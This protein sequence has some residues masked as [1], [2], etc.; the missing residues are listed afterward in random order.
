MSDDEEFEAEFEGEAFNSWADLD[1]TVRDRGGVLRVSMRDL[2][3]LSGYERLKVRVLEQIKSQLADLGIGF[4]P[5]DL[6]GDQNAYVVLYKT[7]SEAGA[8]IDAVRNGSSSHRA[9]AALRELN[10]AKSTQAKREFEL[11][12][13]ELH[14]HLAEIEE[15][16]VGMRETITREVDAT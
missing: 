9:E 14:E 13:K 12:T 11:K 8:V 2:R 3:Y 4:L 1:Q 10:T 16:V 7:G 15:A 5:E 6:P